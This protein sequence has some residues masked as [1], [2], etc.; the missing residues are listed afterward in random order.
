VQNPPIRE[1]VVELIRKEVCL[2]YLRD[3]IDS[4]ESFENVEEAAKKLEHE[5]EI[6]EQ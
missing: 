5:K 6:S 4:S 3:S 1:Q 2:K